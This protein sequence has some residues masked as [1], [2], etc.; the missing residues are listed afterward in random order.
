MLMKTGKKTSYFTCQNIKTIF[1]TNYKCIKNCVYQHV[2]CVCVCVCVCV[3]VCVCVCV[4]VCLS[5][6][7]IPV[8]HLT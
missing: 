3:Y 6:S 1:I 5:V 8:T 7:F 2:V 4:S